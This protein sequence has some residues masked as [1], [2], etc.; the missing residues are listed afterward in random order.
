LSCGLAVLQSCGLCSQLPAPCSLLLA[1]QPTPNSSGG[2]PDGFTSVFGL[3]TSVFL[4][5]HEILRYIAA[6]QQKNHTFATT[7][8]Q[9]NV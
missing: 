8:Y 9:N 7:F 2:E 6:F 1:K 4:L 3:P 5:N